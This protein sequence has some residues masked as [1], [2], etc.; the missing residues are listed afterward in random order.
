MLHIKQCHFLTLLM[1]L[2]GMALAISRGSAPSHRELEGGLSESLAG[3]LSSHNPIPFPKRTNI[4][5][6]ADGLRA[7]HQLLAWSFSEL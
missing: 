5:S 1:L 7:L 2:Q 6:I 4:P 3:I